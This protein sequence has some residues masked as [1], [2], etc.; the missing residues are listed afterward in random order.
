[1]PSLRAAGLCVLRTTARG[2]SPSEDGGEGGGHGGVS[3]GEE[4]LSLS[5]R[6]PRTIGSPHAG[7]PLGSSRSSGGK[8]YSRSFS[9]KE[10]SECRWDM[11][12]GHRVLGGKGKGEAACGHARYNP[13]T[14]APSAPLQYLPWLEPVLRTAVL[15]GR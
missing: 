5:R 1:M 3:G 12:S 2:V 4:A 9:S 6:E 13:C 11:L 15:Q 14:L 8:R 7:F 10:L